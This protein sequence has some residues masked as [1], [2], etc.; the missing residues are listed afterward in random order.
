MTEA[1]TLG[2]WCFSYSTLKVTNYTCIVYMV[3]ICYSIVCLYWY[4]SG[5][6]G[7]YPRSLLPQLF[8]LK[9]INHTCIVYTLYY[10]AYIAGIGFILKYILW[11]ANLVLCA[12]YI[13]L[14][15]GG[16]G[17]RVCVC[18]WKITI[19]ANIALSTFQACWMKPCT[20]CSCMYGWYDVL[21]KLCCKQRSHMLYYVACM[22]C[23]VCMIYYVAST[24][25]ALCTCEIMH[26]VACIYCIVCTK[27]TCCTRLHISSACP[28][29]YICTRTGCMGLWVC[30]FC[31][32]F[33]PSVSLRVLDKCFEYCPY[34]LF[35]H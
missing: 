27:C 26:Y 1:H 18:V 16:G 30:S 25:I 4:K 11:H 31:C 3:I 21:G 22:A 5:N 9:F 34:V 32:G 33:I 2:H 15:V 8:H 28:L 29:T 23:I 7:T 19:H 20:V 6:W 12:Y 14:C 24:R 17:A 13:M 10:V 35:F